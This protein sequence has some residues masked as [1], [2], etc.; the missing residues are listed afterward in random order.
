ARQLLV[1]LC[2]PLAVAFAPSNHE[3]MRL[4]QAWIH[5]GAARY[6]RTELLRRRLE[7]NGVPVRRNGCSQ[8][9]LALERDYCREGACAICPLARLSRG[10]SR[11]GALPS[12]NL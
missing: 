6:G 1:D 5:L 10:P 2:Y 7:L 11:T 8:G 12:T 4:S 9:L 3:A